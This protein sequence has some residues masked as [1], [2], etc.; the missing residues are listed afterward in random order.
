ML[1]KQRLHDAQRDAEDEAAAD[2]KQGHEEQSD[3][4]LS[5]ALKIFHGRASDSYNGIEGCDGVAL[6]TLQRQESAR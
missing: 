6:R 5:L 3:I 1:L 4:G 2:P